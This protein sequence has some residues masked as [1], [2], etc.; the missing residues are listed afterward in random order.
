VASSLPSSQTVFA[1]GAT[2]YV[3]IW[4]QTT[5]SNGLSSVSLDLTYDPSL[6]HAAT[7]THSSLFSAL[8]P[9]GSIDNGAGI[10]NDLSGSHLGSACTEAIAV[11]PNWA[12]VAIVE[13]TTVVPGALLLESR[14]TG[15]AIYGTAV[16][17][18]GDIDPAQI[19]FG[20]STVGLGNVPAVSEWGM[21]VLALSVMVAGSVLLRAHPVPTKRHDRLQMSRGR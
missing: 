8:P 6:A 14:P 11:V 20:R 12:R 15:S 5:H 18:I 3:E 4:V 19:E 1:V 21:V 10:I 2:L 16:C 7:I 9:Q 13:M 17:G